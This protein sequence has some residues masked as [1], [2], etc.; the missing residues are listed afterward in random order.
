MKKFNIL[1]TWNLCVLY[2]SKNKQ[3]ILPY[4]TLNDFFF[5]P[6][7]RVFTARYAQSPYIT[8]TFRL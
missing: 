5:N 4:E 8:H 6:R 3:Q 2:G 7:W 1:I